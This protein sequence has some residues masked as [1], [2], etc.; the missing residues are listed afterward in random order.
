MFLCFSS[1][2]AKP[3]SKKSE[4]IHG[5]W[6]FNEESPHQVSVPG[7]IHSRETELQNHG[8]RFFLFSLSSPSLFLN[9]ADACRS[10]VPRSV[11]SPRRR[12]RARSHAE[13]LALH[14]LDSSAR[15]DEAS[16]RDSSTPTATGR[17]ARRGVGRT[18]RG[19]QLQTGGAGWGS[20]CGHALL[21]REYFLPI[22]SLCSAALEPGVP[23]PSGTTCL[24]LRLPWRPGTRS[25]GSP[26]IHAF[27]RQALPSI[28]GSQPQQSAA[29]SVLV[30]VSVLIFVSWASH[31]C[32]FRPCLIF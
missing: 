23:S 26:S 29:D 28:I 31:S 24:Q 25:A 30:S 17:G 2:V 16:V 14:G 1:F 22:R 21:S 3:R 13:K 11:T 8:V 12:R 19:T 5:A 20:A 18:R 6:G 7:S 15:D 32:V 27:D 4:K 10:P 9:L